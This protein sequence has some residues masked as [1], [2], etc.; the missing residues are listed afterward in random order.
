MQTAVFARRALQ[1][2]GRHYAREAI[3]RCALEAIASANQSGDVEPETIRQIAK[4][5][6][7]GEDCESV[8]VGLA[9]LEEAVRSDL[10]RY[11]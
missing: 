9:K 7:A 2:A 10:A 3:E 1:I 4:R 11:A 8:T 5:I 6:E